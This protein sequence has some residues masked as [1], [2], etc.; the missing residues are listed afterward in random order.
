MAAK[1]RQPLALA[2]QVETTPLP[3]HG[4]FKHHLKNKLHIW[5]ISHLQD[6]L[7]TLSLYTSFMQKSG[8]CT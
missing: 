1:P 5:Q 4:V 8:G 7:F 2:G 6:A 3:R